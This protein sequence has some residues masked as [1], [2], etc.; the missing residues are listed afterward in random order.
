M[1]FKFHGHSF[2]MRINCR[3]RHTIKKWCDVKFLK[4]QYF[5]S[6]ANGKKNAAPRVS[7]TAWDWQPLLIQVNLKNIIFEPKKINY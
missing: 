4:G 7:Y 1:W 6:L 2:V 3:K 5:Y